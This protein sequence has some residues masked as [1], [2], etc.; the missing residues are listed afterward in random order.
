MSII[1]ENKTIINIRDKIW[2][3]SIKRYPEIGIMEVYRMNNGFRVKGAGGGIRGTQTDEKKKKEN[4]E[5]ANQRAGSKIR[6][7]ILRNNL[8]YHWTFH[9]GDDVE[10]RE[11]ASYDFMKF[12]Q[13]LNYHYKKK[14]NDDKVMPT[15]PYVAV[16]EIQ[17]E[18]KR[19]YG[20]EVIHFHVALDRY[21]PFWDIHK[22]WGHGGAWVTP[23]S[24]DIMQVAS[25]MTKY[26]KKVKEDEQVRE[27]E[28]KRYFRSRYL[29]EAEKEQSMMSESE[30]E[31]LKEKALAHCQFGDDEELIN[32]EWIQLFEELNIMEK[33]IPAKM[34]KSTIVKRGGGEKN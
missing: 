12:M 7:L 10:D 26:V 1:A 3:A 30:F 21:L 18:R 17:P 13:R 15:M 2:N 6:E 8:K 22:I 14:I 5:R 20:K 32:A 4:Q 11:Q 25:Y 24:G 9:Y 31:K 29:K 28:Q 34:L 33:D 27:E 23:Y 19:K 16:M